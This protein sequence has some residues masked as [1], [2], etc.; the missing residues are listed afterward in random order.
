ME[1]LYL[2][3]RIP[4]PPNKGDKIRSF[5]HVQHLA[6]SH[7]IH[8][9]CMVDDYEDLEYVSPLRD[10]CQSVYAVYQ[11]KHTMKCKSLLALATG[12]PLSVGSYQSGKFQ[13]Y[14]NSV[15]A[16]QKID[17][18][19][20]FSSVMAQYVQHVSGI[21]KVMDFVDVDSEKWKM[22]VG[23][24]HF[25]LS[26]L[27]R[28]ESR[29]LARFEAEVARSCDCSILVTEE[30]AESLSKRVSGRRIVAVA[31]GVDLSY[32]DS[33]GALSLSPNSPCLIFAG[34][35][36]YFP[37]IDAVRYF[38]SEIFPTIRESLPEVH[39]LI[40][41]RN[42][43]ETVSELGSQPGISV[44]GS[45]PDMRPYL[46]KAW[47]SVA[48]LRI[49]RGIQNKVLE[50]MAM[51]IPVVGTSSAFEGMKAKDDDGI[52]IADTPREFAL[53]V[54]TLLRDMA[55]RQ[56]CSGQARRYVERCHRWDDHC[57]RLDTLVREI[58]ETYRG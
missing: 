7:N 50:A 54:L 5:H 9:A 47:V 55:L 58:A 10:M 1:I 11:S 36:D 41:G 33:N 48:P 24:H 52:R 21:P 16:T 3:H 56:E 29:R 57:S 37:N 45:V 49:A 51:G 38:S 34:A 32:F 25:P 6:K 14:V 13:D 27:Y 30:E 44:I 23:F 22:Y 31:N 43:P 17:V 12:A 4:Y 42:P 53:G 19:L 35:M 39:F 20:M 15:L 26:W 8:V 46:Q 2:A 40:V 28:L 18:I